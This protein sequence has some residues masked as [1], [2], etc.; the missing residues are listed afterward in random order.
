MAQEWDAMEGSRLGWLDAQLTKAGLGTHEA[1]DLTSLWEWY[2]EWVPT[3]RLV[4]GQQQP[5]WIIPGDQEL[6]Y[7]VEKAVAA[8]AVALTMRRRLEVAAPVLERV[9][10][11]PHLKGKYPPVDCN[12]PGLAVRGGDGSLVFGLGDFPHNMACDAEDP[13]TQHGYLQ[14]DF[15]T[16]LAE[17]ARSGHHGRGAVE[18]EDVVE[19]EEWGDGDP[20][21][22]DAYAFE[23]GIEESVAWDH[24]DLVAAYVGAV[25]KLPQVTEAFHQDREQILVAG[26]I[27]EAALVK[28]A[29][30]WWTD[31]L[32]SEE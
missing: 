21:E 30:R 24:E 14:D 25:G 32:P 16:A 1:I 19:V 3:R 27:T 4:R 11:P 15:D 6:V 28:H 7:S 5:V 31:H 20:D 13:A 10:G 26:T 12:E 22:V 29:T 8:D 2:R 23:L 18:P 9:M 17:A